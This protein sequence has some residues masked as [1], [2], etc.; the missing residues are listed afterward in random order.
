MVM[1]KLGAPQKR[2]FLIDPPLKKFGCTEYD[3]AQKRSTDRFPV[4]APVVMCYLAAYSLAR[5][6][7]GRADPVHGIF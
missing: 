3:P 5:V 4:K 2:V 7:H 1:K 6:S